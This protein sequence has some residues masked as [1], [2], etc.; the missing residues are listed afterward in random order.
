MEFGNDF[1]SFCKRK[2]NFYADFIKLI[3]SNEY[4]LIGINNS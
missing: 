4:P 1:V 2:R 3:L